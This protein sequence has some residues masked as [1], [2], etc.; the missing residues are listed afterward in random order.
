[1]KT[2]AYE[3]A[4]GISEHEGNEIIKRAALVAQET[5]AKKAA[6]AATLA[7]AARNTFAGLRVVS[8]ETMAEQQRRAD[9]LQ[10]QEVVAACRLRSN[11]PGRFKT[12]RVD[13]WSAVPDD[14]VEKYS[15][16]AKQLATSLTQRGLYVLCGGIGDGKTHMACGLV[17]A[18]CDA[19]R[20]GRYEKTKDFIDKLRGTWGDVQAT[21]RFKREYERYAL[22]VLDEWQVRNNTENEEIELFRLV[23]M[24]YD[25]GGTTVIISNHNSADEVSQA[26]DARMADRMCDGGGVIVCDWASLRG[27]LKG[28]A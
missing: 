21:A 12:A 14:S 15:I 24:R 1:V 4:P 19:G 6:S 11:V 2:S 16:A 23:D 25:A 3:V 22:L 17:N 8:P 28:A 27:R 7:T 5:A 9:L 20:S 26:I 10:R 18:F 13:D